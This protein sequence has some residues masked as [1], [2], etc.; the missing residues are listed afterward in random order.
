VQYAWQLKAEFA[1]IVRIA[2]VAVVAAILASLVLGAT[3]PRS[4][5]AQ[6]D[7]FRGKTLTM[8]IGYTSGGGYDLYA[9]VLSKHMGRHIPGSPSIVPQN[10]PGAGSLRVANVLY[11]TASKDGLTIGMIGR[12]MAMEPLIGASQPQYDASKF[13]W[14]GSGSDQVSLC[15]TWHTSPVKRWS[16]ML[17]TPFTVGGEGSGS[18]PD[19]FAMLIRNLFG[20]KV[21]LVSGYPGGNEINLAMERGEVDGRCGWSWSSIKITKPDWLSGKRINL[22]LQMGLKKSSEL[23]DVPLI[24]DFARNDR[25]RQ[26]LRLILARQ[27]MG[28]PFLAPPSLPAERAQ[29]LR[30][31]FEATMKDPEF[32]AEAKQRQM[33]V[34][35]M[36]G[37]EIDQLVNELYQTPQDVV[38]ATKAVVAEGAR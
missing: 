23:P 33:D 36:S 4:A 16:D 8:L 37:A 13:T 18:D 12:G 19:M 31:A 28:W 30:Q 32:L 21:R 3:Q 17:A 29:A 7:F 10:M 2:V 1:V 9:R 6:A 22:V 24:M 27:Q 26:I 5:Q 20:V 15:A 14:L 38:A 25:E 11:N 35:P 34:N